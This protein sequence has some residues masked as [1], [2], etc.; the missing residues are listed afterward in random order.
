MRALKMRSLETSHWKLTTT[1]WEQLSKLILLQ[2][3]KKLLKNST[4]YHSVVTQH[5][6]Q[7]EKVKKFDK[8]VSYQLAENQTKLPFWNAVSYCTQQ[9]TISPSGC[10]IWQ[11]VDPMTTSND[12]L[13]GWTEKRIGALP[14]E[15]KRSRP[16]FGGL[17][18]VRSTTA[19]WI[20]AKSWHLRSVL[21][22]STRSLNTA[23]AAAGV[24][25]QKGPDFSQH[26]PTT[27]PTTSASKVEQI[28]LW[29]FASSV[30]YSSDL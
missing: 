9:W 2:L 15:K 10:D 14:W 3:H 6:K 5:L 17:L 29:N 12:Q 23:V 11:N 22:K 28:G 25:Q 26:C 20:L 27:C 24:G 21:S 8:W 13:S 19:F 4:V 1:N 7:T 18:L 16:L 30:I